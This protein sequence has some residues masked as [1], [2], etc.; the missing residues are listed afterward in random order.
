M[1]IVA[2]QLICIIFKDNYDSIEL[3]T[4]SSCFTSS[5]LSLTFCIHLYYIYKD[6]YD[7]TE[8]DTS[9]SCFMWSELSLTF[10]IIYL[11]AKQTFEH[12]QCRTIVCI[13]IPVMPVQQVLGW[14]SKRLAYHMS[15]SSYSTDY[16][17][18]SI[19]CWRKNIGHDYSSR[20]W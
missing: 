12:V 14:R 9:S 19:H 15:W 18:S 13:P 8:L 5:E 1:L 11:N 2:F 20:R 4:P 16:H 3:D 6:N 17:H 7:S 10:C